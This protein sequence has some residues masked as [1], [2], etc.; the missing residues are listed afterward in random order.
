MNRVAVEDSA[1]SL[2]AGEEVLGSVNP[3][4]LLRL[5]LHVKPAGDQLATHARSVVEHVARDRRHLTR[6]QYAEAHGLKAADLQKVRQFVGRS[7]LLLVPDGLARGLS[8]S[9]RAHR[10][11]E[12]EG[13]VGDINRALGTRLVRVRGKDGR[14]YHTHLGPFSIPAEYQGLIANV[15]GLDNRPQVSPRSRQVESLGGAGISG[16]RSH[17]PVEIGQLYGFPAGSGKGQTIAI[18]EMGGGYIAR[19]LRHYFRSLGLQMP[20]IASIGVAGGRNAPTGN[21]NGPDSEVALDIEVAGAI[22]NGARLV[23]YFARN[24]NR[25]F[26]RCVNAAVHD[27]VN[28]PSIISISWGGP[29]ASWSKLDMQSIN[30]SLQAAAAMGISVFVAAGD[31]GLTDTG[32]GSIAHADFP[33]SSPYATACGG[34]RLHAVGGSIVGESVW[35]DGDSGGSG[36]GISDVF[37]LTDAY[38]QAGSGVP[39]SINPGAIQGRGVPDVAGV[40]DPNTGYKVRIDGVDTVFGGTSAVAPLWAGLFALINE[41]LGVPVGFA[42]PL[43]YSVVRSAGALNDVPIG[44]NDTT[45][46]FGGHYAARP[47]AWDPCT[48]LGSPRGILILNALR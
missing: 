6:E 11:V 34:T 4:R 43:L 10:T 13:A 5:T 30:E 3:Q 12:V 42:N 41:S 36:G 22:A 7:G 48:G 2:A 38:Y 20:E 40:A 25:A 9:P 39:P 27:T 29:E 37:P 33:A 18:L 45:G 15:L 35:N 14:V 31:N 28:K 23:V 32:H 44:N 26:L 1:R 17:T 24:N 47:N 46:R 21:P 8:A 16:L 19:D